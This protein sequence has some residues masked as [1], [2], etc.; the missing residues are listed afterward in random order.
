MQHSKACSK[1]LPPEFSGKLCAAKSQKQTENSF[2][3][4]TCLICF[5]PLLKKFNGIGFV[6]FKQYFH[7]VA[8]NSFPL[9]CLWNLTL[10]VWRVRSRSWDCGI[11]H[12]TVEVAQLCSRSGNLDTVLKSLLSKQLEVCSEDKGRKDCIGPWV[13]WETSIIIHSKPLNQ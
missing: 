5:F 12:R 8:L 7:M 1:R 10:C 11:C 6:S 4:S 9:D 2:K 13:D 3:A